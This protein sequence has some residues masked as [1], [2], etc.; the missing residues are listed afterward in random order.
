MSI[1]KVLSVILATVFLAGTFSGCAP[2]TP[3]PLQQ[4]GA[5]IAGSRA[6]SQPGLVIAVNQETPTVAPA[7]HTAAVGHWKNDLTHNGL[8]RSTYDMRVVPSLVREYHAVTDTIWEFTLHEGIL[9]HNMEEMTAYDVYASWHYVRTTPDGAASH[10]SV[11]SIEVIDRY[12]F[13]L[14]TG[15]PNALVFVD[16]HFQANY[17]MP[18]SLIEAGNDFAA[19][20]VG[21]GPFV[22]EEWR[23][24][25]S[26]TFRRFDYFFD[27]DRAPSVDYVHW[28]I[29]PEGT[30]RTIALETGEVNF[31]AHVAVPDLPRLREHPDIYVAEFPSLTMR[32]WLFNHE[33]PRFGNVNVRRALEMAL[34][35]ESMVIAGYDGFGIPIWEQFP[36]AYAGVSSEG[37]RS[38]DPE[39]A[40]EL[41]AQ[42]GIDPASL[43][44]EVFIFT[45]EMRRQ[46]EVAQANLADIGVPITISMMD[47][48][49]WLDVTAQGQFEGAIGNFTASNVLSKIRS[50]MHRNF[51]G[52][53]NRSRLDNSELSDWIDEIVATID[54]NAR[55]AQIYSLTTWA[56]ENPTW[57][58]IHMAMQV[59]AFNSNIVAPELAPGGGLNINMIYWVY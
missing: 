48:A 35:K 59:R 49:T 39:A 44:F 50:T 28:R 27:A 40:R 57:I 42:E 25:D 22:F 10:A 34:D 29:I 26:L 19:N 3:A 36:T 17:I 14:D 31:N 15:V 16:L 2:A 46:A 54:D 37:I 41:L 8:F 4:P 23:P 1:K 12:T 7:R 45:E 24:G 32:W 11:V 13:R 33:D 52:P 5:P 43:G 6:A 38:F 20:P 56:N 47:F 51:I 18:R 30:S 53:Q 9:F 55:L 58:P 21:S